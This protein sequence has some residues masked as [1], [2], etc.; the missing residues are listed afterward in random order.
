MGDHSGCFLPLAQPADGVIRAAKLECSDALKILTLE[1]EPASRL[2][3]ESV[4]RQNRRMMG[5]TGD[6]LGRLK[7]CLGGDHLFLF[8][9]R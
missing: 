3:I 9:N 7:N 6:L 8:V 5:E 1:I 4:G 2:L